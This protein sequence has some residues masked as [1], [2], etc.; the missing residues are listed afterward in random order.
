MP[1]R[2]HSQSTSTTSDDSPDDA[3]RSKRP[4]LSHVSYDSVRESIR[5]LPAD[6]NDIDIK[7]G[8]IYR[9]PEAIHTRLYQAAWKAITVYGDRNIPVDNEARRVRILEAVCIFICPSMLLLDNQTSPS[10][11]SQ[12]LAFLRDD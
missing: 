5:S 8:H 6:P 9:L 1:K 7:P 12:L 3:P 11:S 2:K 10:I 4:S